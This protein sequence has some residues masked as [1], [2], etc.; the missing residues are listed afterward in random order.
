MRA[1]KFDKMGGID[2]SE[3]PFD[4]VDALD[5]MLWDMQ[6]HDYT[7]IGITHD[8]R[9]IGVPTKRSKTTVTTRIVE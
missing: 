2:K 1:V 7:S 6:G 5:M 4:L 8:G 3:V 9:V